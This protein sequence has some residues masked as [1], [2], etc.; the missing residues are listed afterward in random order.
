VRRLAAEERA[1]VE[2]APTSNGPAAA[3][4]FYEEGWNRY[5]QAWP[6]LYP[7]LSHL[8]DEWVGKAAGAASSLAE[9]EALIE[10]RFIAPYILPGDTVL[11]IGVGGGRTSALLLKHCD[12][13]I[14]AD[15]SAAMLEATRVRLATP[16]ATFVK[17]DGL[18]FD[19]LAGGSA[20]VC[21]CYDTMVHM[22]P[23][24]I[25]NY[26]TLIPRVLRGKRLCV[27]HHGET[28]SDLGWE[29]FLSE[30][31]LNLRGDRSGTA[32]SVMTGALME[33]FLKHL[34]YEVLL[35]D[36][37]SV[38]RDRVVVCRAPVAR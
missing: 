17:L 12:R 4:S 37:L 8:G 27:F 25:F 16:R 20:D 23:R 13:L 19:G 2:T 33:H 10:S 36:S 29:K 30:W 14:C 9:Y 35:Q 31:R 34:R 15:V 6:E 1:G 21:F 26:L 5:A 22:E 18:D 7:E 32:F 38:P 11:E 28:L 3:A 24:D